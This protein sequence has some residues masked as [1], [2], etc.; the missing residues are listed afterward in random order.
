MRRGIL[1]SVTAAALLAWGPAGASQDAPRRTTLA[2]RIDQ[3]LDARWSKASVAPPAGDGEFLRRLSLD[4]RGTLPSEAEARAFLAGDSPNKRLEKIE[5]YL[6]SPEYA[7]QW[8]RIWADAMFP[9]Y[10]DVSVQFGKNLSRETS[11]RMMARLLEWMERLIAKDVPFPKIMADLL[12]AYGKSEENPLILYKLSFYREGGEPALEFADGVSR[13]WI[14]V[15]IS[16]ARCHDHPF[17][18]WRQEDYYGLAAFFARQRVK[19]SGVKGDACSEVELSEDAR[20]ELT[21][22]ET[23]RLALPHFLGG[24]PGSTEPRMTVL[25]RAMSGNTESGLPR[26]VANRVWAALMGRGLVHPVDDFS[27]K[28][29]ELHPG[30][31]AALTREFAAHRYSLKYLIRSICATRA[32]Q[33]SSGKDGAQKAE[34]F[35]RHMTRQMRAGALIHALAAATRGAPPPED[36]GAWDR[37]AHQLRLI[38]GPGVPFNEMTPLP[39]NTRQALMLRNSDLVAGLIRGSPMLREAAS[40]GGSVEE[41]IERVFLAALTRR[42]EPSELERWKGHLARSGA[43]IRGFEDLLWTL[44]NTSEFSTRH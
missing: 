43:D 40:S 22:P 15:R 41:R 3:I 16:C 24:K 39:G 23:G 14:G 11:R 21:M 8:A 7:A 35:S 2:S 30:L 6:A 20:G 18:D 13:T 19:P 36:D 26:A 37:F 28:N 42:P 1:F 10:R 33:L 34:D 29:K 12:E 4:L 9:N 27:R 44:I 38:Y 32:Y 31:L 17:D 5:E 25:A